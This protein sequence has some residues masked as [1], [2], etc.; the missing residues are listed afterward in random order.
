MVLLALVAVPVQ[1]AGASGA[2]AVVSTGGFHPGTWPTFQPGRHHASAPAGAQLTYYGGPVV[3]DMRSVDVSYGPDSYVAAGHPGAGTMAAF[4]GQFLG[5][6]VNDWLAEYG[7]SKAG[8]TH[9][10]IGRGTYGGTI[11]ITPAPADDGSVVTDAQVQAELNAQITAGVLPVPDA[12]TSYTVFF[13]LGQ[14]ICQGGSCS[15]VAGGFCAYHGTFLRNGSA[16]TYQVMPDL[17]GTTGCGN[18]NDLGNTTSVLSHELTETI[19]DP[20]VGLATVVGPPLGWY[21]T[22]NGEIGDICNAQQGTFVGTDAV[23][24]TVQAEFS[25]VRN[26]CI[27]GTV[28]VP[29]A[30]VTT[31]LAPGSAGVTYLQ[32]LTASGGN[33]PYTWKLVK[34][35][36]ALPKGVKLS[37]AGILSG[38]PKAAGTYS[39]TVEAL[40]TKSSTKPKTQN[41]ATQALTLTVT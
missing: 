41:T 40:D 38:T 28:P 18:S 6:G 36:G 30:V 27:V 20:N 7:T 16:V 29:L 21:D 35:S 25:D 32:T 34:A 15:L 24:Y 9:Q 31:T 5:S 37:K 14:R 19:T 23:T 22:T 4:T 26:D 17:T 3:S 12:N 1:T 2:P 10:T 8:G 39:F 11:T 33:A 13:P